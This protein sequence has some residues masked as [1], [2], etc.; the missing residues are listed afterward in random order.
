M[1]INAI[2]VIVSCIGIFEL[3]I[4]SV[5]SLYKY[6]VSCKPRRSVPTLSEGDVGRRTVNEVGASGGRDA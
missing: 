5:P 2:I 4:L 3:C 1:V 6:C